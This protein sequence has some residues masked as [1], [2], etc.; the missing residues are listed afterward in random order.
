MAMAMTMSGRMGVGRRDKGEGGLGGGPQRGEG[1]GGR[2]SERE[3]SKSGPTGR[4]RAVEVFVAE[5]VVGVRVDVAGVT[6]AVKKSHKL[7]FLPAW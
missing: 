5:R 6:R 2:G 4:V 3:E 1:E 7:H